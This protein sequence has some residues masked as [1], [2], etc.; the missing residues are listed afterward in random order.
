MKYLL[1]VLSTLVL[2]VVIK[3]MWGYFVVPLGVV[4]IN[5]AHAMGLVFLVQLPFWISLASIMLTAQGQ[6]VEPLE[7]SLASI[8]VS[9][10]VLFVS[11]ILSFFI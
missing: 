8:L 5:V 10:I 3:M 11:W 4:P 9:F 7:R 6:E 2:A 1:G